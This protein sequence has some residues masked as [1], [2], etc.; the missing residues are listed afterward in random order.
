[1]GTTGEGGSGEV[2]GSAGVVRWPLIDDDEEGANRGVI[3]AE[4]VG[5]FL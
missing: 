2:I 5:V 3:S 4:V 1:M